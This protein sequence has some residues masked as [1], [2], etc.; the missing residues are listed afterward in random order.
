MA[1]YLPISLLLVSM[2][3]LPPAATARTVY[4]SADGMLSVRFSSYIK[5]LDFGL[6]TSLPGTSVT[7]EDLTRA[8]L[9]LE[10]DIGTHISLTV[11]YEPFWVIEPSKG[12]TTGLFSGSGSARTHRL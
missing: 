11:H 8:R 6:A 9:M 1:R 10:G 7:A 3:C 5:T 12:T 2:L 4:S